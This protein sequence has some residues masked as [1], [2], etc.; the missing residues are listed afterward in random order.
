MT[1]NFSQKDQRILGKIRADKAIAKRIESSPYGNPDLLSMGKTY[2]K[3][4]RERSHFCVI[5]SVSKSGMDMVF[6]VH[7][8]L[9]HSLHR[10]GFISKKECDELSQ[11]TP[12][13]L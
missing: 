10:L 4:V 1:K 2:L 6:H 3:A 7:Y 9:I 11:E 5:H 13:T 12:T 8:C